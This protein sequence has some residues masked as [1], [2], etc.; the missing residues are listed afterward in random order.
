MSTP[1]CPIRVLKLLLKT[2]PNPHCPISRR[3]HWQRRTQIAHH[4]SINLASTAKGS[5][6]EKELEEVNF[7]FIDA[8]LVRSLIYISTPL[9]M[10][11]ACNSFAEIVVCMAVRIHQAII[12]GS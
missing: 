11:D 6:G 9:G 5:Y 7:A 3:N 10:T 4:S 8:R 12:A 1:E 2:L